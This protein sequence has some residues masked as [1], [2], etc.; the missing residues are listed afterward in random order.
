MN[1]ITLFQDPDATTSL[2]ELYAR[3]Y[4]FPWPIAFQLLKRSNW[5]RIFSEELLDDSER[6]RWITDHGGMVL[7][8][9]EHNLYRELVIWFPNSAS[10]HY[11]EITAEEYLID[12]VVYNRISALVLA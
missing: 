11:A 12:S 3:T 8:S 6:L 7:L 10:R 2:R 9:P 1:N 5:C 4:R